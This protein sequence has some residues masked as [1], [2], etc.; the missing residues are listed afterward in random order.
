MGLPYQ[1]VTTYFI[2]I[3][4]IVG[5]LSIEMGKGSITVGKINLKWLETFMNIGYYIGRFITNV[6]DLYHILNNL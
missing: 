6:N 1:K 2:I 3:G 5:G 4:I